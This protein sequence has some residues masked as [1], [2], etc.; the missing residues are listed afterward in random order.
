VKEDFLPYAM[1]PIEAL[2]DGRL[3]LTQ[4]RV[5]CGLLSFRRRDTDVVF[6]GRHE[7]A[8]RIG[9]AETRISHTTEQLVE[10]GWLTKKAN[11]GRG[12]K[13]T[14]K[15][16]IP[17][18]L[19]EIAIEKMETKRRFT[20]NK[21]C[22][23]VTELVTP[24]E[25]AGV[26]EPVTPDE[27]VSCSGV[28]ELVTPDEAPGVTDSVTVKVTDSVTPVSLDE[29]RIEERIVAPCAPLKVV[30]TKTRKSRAFVPPT[31]EEVVA[32]VQSRSSTV[33][34]KIF[35]EYFNTGNWHDSKGNA[36]VNWKQK[37]ITWESLGNGQAKPGHPGQPGRQAAQSPYQQPGPKYRLV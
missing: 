32:Y 31:L 26:T 17:P 4:L 35:W 18:H 13:V 22:S 19:T 16:T 30:A 2:M 37:L 21:S 11:G 9:I 24:D 8:E 14:Y 6:P 34:P 7:L 20:P 27:D 3:T 15:V 1:V 33:D 10:L 25:P 36:V 29:E 5:L 23:G 12:R 28:T